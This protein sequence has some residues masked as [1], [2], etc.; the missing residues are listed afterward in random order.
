M[1]KVA[2]STSDTIS[3]LNPMDM[4][5]IEM[6]VQRTAVMAENSLGQ[7]IFAMNNK[8]GFA[9]QFLLKIAMDLKKKQKNHVM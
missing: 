4:L 1:Q 3:L 2:V 5:W 6:E 9:D 7:I 8:K